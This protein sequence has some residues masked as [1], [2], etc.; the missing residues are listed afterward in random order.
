[1]P[2]IQHNHLPSVERIQHEG[3]QVFSQ[4]EADSSLSAIKVGFLNMMPDKAL[5][6]TERQFLRLVAANK[7]K[8]CYVFPFTIDGVE[9]G[10]EA[11]A[12]VDQFY[13]NLKELQDLNIDALVVTGANVARAELT[14]E[15]FWPELAQ[16]LLW[17]EKNIK[18]TICSCLATHAACK[19]FYHL[20]RTRLENKCW[21]VFE[22]TLVDPKHRITQGIEAKTWMCHSRFNGISRAELEKNAVHVLIESNSAGVQLAIDEARNMIYMQGH[23]EYDDISLLKEYKREVVRF[24]Q[25]HVKHYPLM[26]KNYFNKKA[27]HVLSDFQKIMIE[28]NLRADTLAMFPE[29]DVRTQVSNQWQSTAERIFI[30]WLDTV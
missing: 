3:A 25:G 12:H 7:E 30:N 26:P 11:Q 19:I 29:A 22:H 16:T 27:Q 5:A 28:S 8:N 2:L 18:S 20:D 14:T 6:A 1:M 23:P 17:A 21:G 9:R 10:A 24:A 4:H 13:V 15:L